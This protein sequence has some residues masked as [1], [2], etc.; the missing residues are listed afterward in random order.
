VLKCI[1]FVVRV[2]FAL[3]HLG[4]DKDS[5][6]GGFQR[7]VCPMLSIIENGLTE[8]KNQKRASTGTRGNLE[9]PTK[10]KK[11]LTPKKSSV[12][13]PA[14]KKKKTLTLKKSSVSLPPTKK[15][16]T[17]TSKKS[18]V[19]PGRNKSAKSSG[20]VAFQAGG[21][22]N[23]LPTT[24]AVSLDAT[25]VVPLDL[26]ANGECVVAQPVVPHDGQAETLENAVD[27][28]P[29]TSSVR[30]EGYDRIKASIQR[31]IDLH[32]KG[33]GELRKQADDR[34]QQAQDLLKSLEDLKA[35]KQEGQE[36]EA[37]VRRDIM[38]KLVRGLGPL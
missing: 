31:E 38:S 2:F 18:S 6:E 26:S 16:K 27:A 30:T 7:H 15:K 11:T 35:A 37:R 19:S 22:S 12:S 1:I 21:G 24:N 4:G 32:I 34:I 5:L 14:T 10:K 8:D 25:L 23:V 36:I 3:K 33:A 28:N 9:P 17:L 29:A 13:L 20:C